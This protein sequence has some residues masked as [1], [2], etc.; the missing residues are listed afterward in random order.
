MGL[1]RL[2]RSIWVGA[3]TA[4]LFAGSAHGADEFPPPMDT[5]SDQARAPDAPAPAA[6]GAASQPQPAAAEEAS[7]A[8]PVPPKAERDV[9]IEE[10]H[11]GR[12][13]SEVIVTPA[14]FTYHYTLIH[15]DDQEQGTSPLQPHQELSVPRFFRLDF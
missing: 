4:V 9:R 5:R 8:Q 1:T 13:V 3:V 7:G 15:L 14:G 11:V 6:A 12:R 10:K 2:G